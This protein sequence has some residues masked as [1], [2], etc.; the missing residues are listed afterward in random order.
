MAVRA[1]SARR[2]K[3]IKTIISGSAALV[4]VVG[5]V[6]VVT[7]L[8][9]DDGDGAAS[10]AASPESCV[11]QPVADPSAASPEPLP[12]GIQQVGAPDESSVVRSGVQLMTL[13]TSQGTL[14]I[15]VETG[16]APCTAASFTHLAG[17]QFFDETICHRLTTEGIYV[18]QCGDPSGSGMGGPDYRIRDENL[19]VDKVPTYPEGT[20]AMANAGAN[21]NG[22]QFF[23]VYQDSELPASY[24]VFGHVLQGLDIIKRVASTGVEPTDPSNP[25]DGAPKAEVKIASMIIDPAAPSLPDL[26]PASPLPAM[27]TPSVA[28]SETASPA[29]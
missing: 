23:I 1:E 2:R 14:R 4:V 15:Q 27:S 25:G 12:D 13:N 7:M 6:V 10:A 19:P 24:T 21:T 3:R 20:V 8:A 18:I 16:K 28:P 17:Q 29:S 5:A 11:Y 22:S 26:P 9:M